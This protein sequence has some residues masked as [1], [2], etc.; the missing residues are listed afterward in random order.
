VPLLFDPQSAEEGER[1]RQCYTELF[2]TGRERGFI[3]YR[4]GTQFM[5]NLVDRDLCFW[6][7]AGRLKE[8]LDP[9][10]VLAPGRYSSARPR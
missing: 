9:G 2:L 7:L 4:V 8:T 3:P 10:M 6:G 1:A 5:S